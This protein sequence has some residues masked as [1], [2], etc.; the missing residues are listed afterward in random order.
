MLR[1]GL[2]FLTLFTF[3]THT[4]T[5]VSAIFRPEGTGFGMDQ[6]AF[7][8]K[9]Q[10]FVPPKEEPYCNKLVL[11]RDGVTIQRTLVGIIIN[12][13]FGL[14]NGICGQQLVIRLKTYAAAYSDGSGTTQFKRPYLRGGHCL[15]SASGPSVE[16]MEILEDMVKCEYGVDIEVSK[17]EECVSLQLTQSCLIYHGAGLIAQK[18]EETKDPALYLDE[19]WTPKSFV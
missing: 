18:V 6:D 16:W 19:N 15:I 14:H 3:L 9:L 10:K 12:D 1:R 13:K 4:T 17:P 5:H 2:L 7:W 11:E 8:E